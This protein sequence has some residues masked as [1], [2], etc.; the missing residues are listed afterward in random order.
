[1]EGENSEFV[2]VC[3]DLNLVYPTSGDVAL[4]RY[5]KYKYFPAIN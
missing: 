2:P 5:L 3:D 4:A 1:M